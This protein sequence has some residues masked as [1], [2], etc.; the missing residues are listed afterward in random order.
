[1]SVCLDEEGYLYVDGVKVAKLDIA[2]RVLVFFDKDRRRC[3]T[4]GSRFVELPIDT[5][6]KLCHTKKASK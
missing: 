3:V 2:R 6:H 1:M 4:R 5:V